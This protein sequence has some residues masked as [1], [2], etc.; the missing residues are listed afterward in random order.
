MIAE[1]LTIIDHTVPLPPILEWKPKPVFRTE[2]E[3]QKYWDLEKI[4]W[5]E[6]V[7][8]IPGSL[9]HKTQEQKIKNRN[10]GQI[11]RPTCRDVDLLK[12]Q[13]VRDC[14]A[15]G[16]ALGEVKPRGI[17]L[18][19]DM[20]CFADW[21]M[22]VYPGSTSL[23]T[24]SE[25]TKIGT[26][27]SDK[28]M[29]T[30]NNYDPDI[31][32][33]I[34]N[35]NETKSSVYLKAEVKYRNDEG[36]IAFGESEV[37]CKE[38]ADSDQSASGFSSKGA[39]FAGIDEIHLHKRRKMLL[40]SAA[41]CFIEQA[42]GDVV[43]FVYAGG[44]VEH[45]L[46]N[47][48]L[49]DLQKF[50]NDIIKNGRLGTLPAEFLF[51]PAWMGKFM[52]NG[53]SNEKKAREAWEKECE[54]LSKMESESS[55]RAYQM[56]NPMSLEDVFNLGGGA[57]ED[58]VNEKIKTQI[59]IIKK[60]PPEILKTTFV[61]MGGMVTTTPTKRP[62]IFLLE[63][64]KP[65][66]LYYQVIDG[67][68]TGLKQGEKDGSKIAGIIVKALDLSTGKSYCP[69]CIYYEKP[70]TIE[71]G[72]IILANQIKYYNK[73]GGFK[74]SMIESNIGSAD[75]FSTFMEREGMG[76]LLMHRRDLSGKGNSNTKKIGQ[77]V[78]ADVLD[79]YYRFMNIFLRKYVH[80]IDMLML[81]EDLLLPIEENADMR[82]AFL[83]L[84]SALPIDFDKPVQPKPVQVIAPRPRL[85]MRNGA[86]V[87]VQDQ[88]MRPNE[89]AQATMNQP[90][91]LTATPTPPPSA[92][93]PFHNTN[94]SNRT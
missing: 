52:V 45:T 90:V 12:H 38:T 30:F 51:I 57:W 39:I 34:L 31:R 93:I 10:T 19:C 94:T 18:S 27:F 28:V 86:M 76:K 9:Y 82:S 22:Q 59:N 50:I 74:G 83:L 61:N 37:F 85:E 8:E 88:P 7:G 11:F 81:L 47:T 65:N 53:H 20:G 24:S 72:Y 79:Y 23:F 87:W 17:G 67:V 60:N 5:R 80:N 6:G 16:K 62:N 46:T 63:E 89:I 75:H 64:P 48:Q 25:Q 36:E 13:K 91:P 84:A 78:T 44:S 14:R 54:A 2:Y 33:L 3:R 58:D 32:P 66:V 73:H 92:F 29:V 49:G 43:G 71:Q 77:Y 15:S 4:K 56:N 55:L 26:M 1:S 21:F 41:S 42:T 70:N 69:V 40:E 68:G 35:K